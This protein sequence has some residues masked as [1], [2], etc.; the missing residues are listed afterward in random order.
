MA[1][2]SPRVGFTLAGDGGAGEGGD[3]LVDVTA[4]ISNN[5]SLIDKLLGIV[6]FTTAAGKPTTNNYE[7]K[8]AQEI[9][10]GNLFIYDG[11]Q[12]QILPGT[13]FNCTSGTRPSV[14]IY[15]LRQ[16]Q[17]IYETNTKMYR[18]WDN[19]APP[20]WR[21]VRG[22]SQRIFVDVTNSAGY[23]AASVKMPISSNA[24]NSTDPNGV[25]TVDTVN[26]EII[27]NVAGYY[28]AGANIVA[29]VNNSNALL[30]FFLP[31]GIYAHQ[32]G[33]FGPSGA[34]N[35]QT[36]EFY[37][38]AGQKLSL[39]LYHYAATGTSFSGYYTVTMV[40]EL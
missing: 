2:I 4:H 3:D 39:Q 12:W 25:F 33:I 36:S 26:R 15:A 22:V 38:S 40:S 30:T 7:G 32:N 24:P 9:D 10:N 6:R 37:A 8:I 11:A 13:V 35:A 31:G 19:G 5:Y 28:R 34:G 27:F 20:R 23:G 17:E 18:S 14:P 16:G 29:S 1:T 21:W